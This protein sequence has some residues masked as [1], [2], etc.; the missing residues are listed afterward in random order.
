MLFVNFW[1]KYLQFLVP[2]LF[3]SKMFSEIIFYLKLDIVLS[4]S[5]L[6]TD[7]EFNQ[8]DII[9][10]IYTIEVNLMESSKS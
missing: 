9:E 6:K 10:L 4:F 1:L 3:S 7:R 2:N 5:L 8:L